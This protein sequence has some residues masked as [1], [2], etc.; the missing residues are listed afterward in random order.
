[1]LAIVPTPSRRKREDPIPQT[2]KAEPIAENPCCLGIDAAIAD[3]DVQVLS[4]GD[5]VQRS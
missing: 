2:I 4:G 1:M 5:V 3:S